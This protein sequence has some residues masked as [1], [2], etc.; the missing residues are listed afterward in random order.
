VNHSLLGWSF[1]IAARRGA[2]SPS[3]VRRWG[4]TDFGLREA[5]TWPITRDERSSAASDACVAGALGGTPARGDAASGGPRSG[6]SHEITTPCPVSIPKS[7]DTRVPGADRSTSLRG[8]GSAGSTSALNRGILGPRSRSACDTSPPNLRWSDDRPSVFRVRESR[9]KGTTPCCV[10]SMER[11]EAPPKPDIGRHDSSRNSQCGRA[12]PRKS[13]RSWSLGPQ[14]AR[15]PGSRPVHDVHVT[16]M[17]PA[18][19]RH[20][21][22]GR[23]GGTGKLSGSTGRQSQCEAAPV[24]GG[25][26]R[27]RR[28]TPARGTCS[29]RRDVLRPVK[30]SDRR[31][32]RSWSR[33]SP[34]T[35]R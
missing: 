34:S 10:I 16:G 20:A 21:W 23:A 31:A 22:T 12:D 2:S 24:A 9:K 25:L 5:S 14:K 17:R 30:S 4:S 29:R 1:G 3:H 32:Q 8:R 15:S 7:A 18:R 19:D 26:R 27:E 33:Q 6:A 28:P 11:P 13:G 35:M